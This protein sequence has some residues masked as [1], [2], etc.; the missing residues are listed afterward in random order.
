M[1]VQGSVLKVRYVN[2]T[3]GYC[4]FDLNTQDGV[5]KVVGIFDSI[6]VG[7]I[8][9]IEGEFEYDNKYG[10]Q[11]SSKTYTKK[12]PDSISEIENYLSSGI[13]SNIGRKNAKL[14]VEKFKNKS[15][16]IVFDQTEK[17]LDINGIGKKTIEKIKKSVKS[18]KK[19][20]DILFYLIKLGI[21]LSLSK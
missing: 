6:S 16:D 1:K 12:L 20:K 7:E 18:L 17:L 21:S 8:L 11:I 3:N 9:E 13:I 4:V 19:S 2:D 5:V 14:I 15:L 10:E